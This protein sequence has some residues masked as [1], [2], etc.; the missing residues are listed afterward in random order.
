[1]KSVAVEP[2]VPDEEVTPQPLTVY[3]KGLPPVGVAIR[4]GWVTRTLISFRVFAPVAPLVPL[5]PAAPLTPRLPAQFEPEVATP[6]PAP[7]P[8]PEPPDADP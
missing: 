7:P 3:V 8:E 1:M 6:P 5:A 4:I 2:E